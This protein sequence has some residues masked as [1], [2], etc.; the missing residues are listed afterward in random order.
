MEQSVQTDR[1]AAY[2][3]ELRPHLDDLDP[4]ERAEVLDELADALREVAAEHD[5]PLRDV[6]GPPADYVDAYRASAG[7]EPRPR[8]RGWLAA[9]VAGI[10]AAVRAQPWW[11]QANALAQLLRPAWWTL[12]GGTLAVLLGWV[13]LGSLHW[14]ITL[15][16]LLSIAAAV[17]TSMAARD[18][19]HL[20]KG[21]RYVLAGANVIA[22]L[23][24]L[25][26]MS[27]VGLA[28]GSDWDAGYEAGAMDSEAMAIGQLTKPNGEPV[29]NIYPY[30]RDGEPLEDVLLFDG[31][32]RPLNVAVHEDD[33]LFGSGDQEIETE[34]DRDADGQPITNLYPLQQYILDYDTP[35]GDPTRRPRTV[36]TIVL[37]PSV[38]PEASEISS[39]RP[40]ASA[41]PVPDDS[42]S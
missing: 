17:A 25:P 24:V 4:S 42:P 41:P 13:L 3:D 20:S 15:P 29:T 26:M 22:A 9:R 10:D 28:D 40:E 12:R 11:P 7:L 19:K 39:V 21:L 23:A 8:P 37:P 36:P 31:A 18:G 2:L 6:L 38:R 30:T 5:E 34:Y 16:G 32:G 27:S 35:S 1:V 14:V 33:V